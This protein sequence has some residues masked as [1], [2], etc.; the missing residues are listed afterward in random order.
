MLFPFEIIGLLTAMRGFYVLR[1][2]RLFRCFYFYA[3][4]L[5]FADILRRYNYA[6]TPGA[7]RVV[8]FTVTLAVVGHVAACMFYNVALNN[9]RDGISN[10]WLVVDGLA[11]IDDTDGTFELLESVSFRYVRAI[12]WSVQTLTTVGFGDLGAHSES[13]TW[14]CVFY[15]LVVAVLVNFT[16]ANLT[17]AITNFDAAYTEN[18]KKINRF[19]KYAAYR[20]LPPALTNRV[21]SYYEHQWK[22][23]RGMD[24]L[25]VC[26]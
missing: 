3:Y 17:M 11:V 12:Y 20:K 26:A 15:F 5:D 7:Q 10:N 24:E 13:E 25:Q 22:K 19:E 4:W 16:L 21:V 2:I 9:L 8:V 23:L 14:F 6:T 1:T 18:L